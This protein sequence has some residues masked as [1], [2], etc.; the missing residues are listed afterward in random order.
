[1]STRP[2][3]PVFIARTEGGRVC[4]HQHGSKHAARNCA[5][6]H[7][8]RRGAEA[9]MDAY[10]VTRAEGT[11]AL[12]DDRPTVAY[13]RVWRA[14]RTLRGARVWAFVAATQARSR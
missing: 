3:H 9:S 14:P 2:T 7:N 12:E 8:A 11:G 10:C 1:M 4:G 5:L 13:K 6:T